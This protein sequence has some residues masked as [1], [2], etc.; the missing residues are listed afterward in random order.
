MSR[1]I[2]KN[3]NKK[4]M[5]TTSYFFAL[6]GITIL[7]SCGSPSEK[8]ESTEVAEASIA[9]AP[10]PTLAVNEAEWVE[11][12]LSTI[13]S[14]INISVKLPKDAKLEKNGNGGVDVRINDFYMLTV[15]AIAVSNIKEGIESDKSLTVNNVSSYI[16]GKVLVE[17]P[18]GFAYSMQMKDEENGIKYEPEAH[19]AYYI[20]KDGAVYSILDQRPLDNFSVSGA[21]YSEDI[22]NKVYAIIKASAKAN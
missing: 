20:E 18:N 7:A 17:E 22:A 12:N 10:I 6:A 2:V 19:F 16:N 3:K 13:S 11:Q 9:A 5:K 14:F 4:N 1:K 21:A 15:S 8:T